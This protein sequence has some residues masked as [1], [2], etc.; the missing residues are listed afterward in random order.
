MYSLLEIVDR[1]VFLQI[2]SKRVLCD[3]YDHT[4]D[5]FHDDHDHTCVQDLHKFDSRAFY[6]ILGLIFKNKIG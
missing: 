5:I 1:Y 3:K 6:K 4:M 2:E